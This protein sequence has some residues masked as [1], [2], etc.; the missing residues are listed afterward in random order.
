MV[1]LD[2]RLPICIVVPMSD[3]FEAL[4]LLANELGGK[5]EPTDDD[6]L[7]LFN[8]LD[9]AKKRL[10]VLESQANEV[11][12]EILDSTGPVT[13]DGTRKL[14]ITVNKSTKCTDTDKVFKLLFEAVQGDEDAVVEHFSS[15]PFKPAKCKQ[16]IGPAAMPLF[17][18]ETKRTPKGDAE[19]KP[20][21]VDDTFIKGKTDARPASSGPNPS[22]SGDTAK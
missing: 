6:A 21:V 9:L 7:T 3:V 12:L 22:G 11:L 20:A 17:I 10:K 14:K 8:A 16:T 15:Q 1:A 13:I 5:D 4:Q 19:L 2:K 18:T